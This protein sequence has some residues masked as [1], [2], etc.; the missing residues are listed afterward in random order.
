V[1]L[2]DFVWGFIACEAL[3]F[4]VALAAMQAGAA[5]E[6]RRRRRCAR[7]FRRAPDKQIERPLGRKLTEEERR[8]FLSGVTQEVRSD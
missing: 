1:S 7:D 6:E 2:G 3:I 8:L 4:G 5:A